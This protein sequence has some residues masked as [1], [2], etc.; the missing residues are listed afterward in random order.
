MRSL[1]LVKRQ[2][3]AVLLVKKVA[4]CCDASLVVKQLVRLALEC[5]LNKTHRGSPA[6]H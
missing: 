2:K 6:K 1:L 4:A 3:H 5:W